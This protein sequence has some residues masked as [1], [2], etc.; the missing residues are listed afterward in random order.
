M[1]TSLNHQ[2]LPATTRLAVNNAITAGYQKIKLVTKN[3]HGRNIIIFSDRTVEILNEIGEE[4]KEN[5]DEVKPFFIYLPFQVITSRSYFKKIF[6]LP[7]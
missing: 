3:K 2:Q 5:P 6:P 1:L 7:V 4:T